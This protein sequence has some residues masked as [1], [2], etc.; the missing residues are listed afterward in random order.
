MIQEI[1]V[2][3]FRT[4]VEG[5]RALDRLLRRP[6]F[7]R[8]WCIQEAT[9]SK[10]CSC[11][12]EDEELDFQFLL[13]LTGIIFEW[14]GID[15]TDT[16]PLQLWQTIGLRK[17]Q[18][19]KYQNRPT[20]EDSL[21]RILGILM[22]IRNLESKDPRDR[23][24]AILGVS[25]EGLEPV[26]GLTETLGNQD[27][28][29]ITLLQKGAI[30]LANK[31]NSIDA[32]IDIARHPALKPDYSKST[33]DIYRDFTRYCL[34]RSPRVLD[35]LGHVQHHSDPD[36]SEE[37]PSWVPKFDEPR[38][39]S[40]FLPGPYI[41]G[42]PIRGRYPYYAEVHD[43]PLRPDNPFRSGIQ[44]PNL[45]QLDG[46]RVDEVEAVTE[47]VTFNNYDEFFPDILWSQLYNFP[48]FPR[49]NEHYNPQFHHERL[50]VAFLLTLVLGGLA[51][52][53]QALVQD[54]GTVD[55]S[56]LLNAIDQGEQLAKFDI[57]AWLRDQHG[58]DDLQYAELLEHS[59]AATRLGNAVLFRKMASTYCVN[60]RIYRTQ[61]GIFGLGP[62]IM[63][64]GDTVVVLFGGRYPFMLRRREQNWVLLGD[65]YLRHRFIEIGE[66]AAKM[67]GPA[68]RG[69]VETFR[70]C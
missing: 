45:L 56:N 13:L 58:V 42:I 35:V 32:A 36:P 3:A 57:L 68:G 24:F 66:E 8:V 26:L 21:G 15:S 60:R 22:I 54:P 4:N 16:S 2:D 52:L 43:N 10:N 50:D 7:E 28:Q 47:P 30:W 9:V 31:I 62:R 23:I 18:P 19:E 27:S 14:R 51:M 70:L 34:S 53:G 40:F 49:P 41:A 64:P 44:F 61:S 65:T 67:K 29:G 1:L 38:L 20:P 69:R 17:V 39:V 37:F 25:E 48:L 63:Q 12:I 5:A 6:Y 55:K 11:R 33:R 46:W 59:Q